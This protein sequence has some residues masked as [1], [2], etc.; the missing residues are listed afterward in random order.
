MGVF[1]VVDDSEKMEDIRLFYALSVFICCVYQS[2]SANPH[3]T[4]Q[5][6]EL[7]GDR[8]DLGSGV[9]V[10]VYRGIP[11][12]Q[13]PTGPLR[14]KPPQ[15]PV[16]WTGV[17]YVT[18]DTS[19]CL[20]GKWP[21]QP[22]ESEDCLYL[23]VYTP[24]SATNSSGFD[25]M[26]V[27][28]WIHGGGFTTGS[29]N[30]YNSTLLAGKGVVVVTVNYRLG[31][32]GFF[33]SNDGVIPGNFGL[34]DQVQALKWVKDNIA[35]FRGDPSQVTIFGESAG[36]MSVSP[37]MISPVAKG[38]THMT[39]IPF[40]FGHPWSIDGTWRRGNTPADDEVSEI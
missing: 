19:Q 33:S 10:D 9:Y 25:N 14:L 3:V 24:S 32:M 37:L 1:Q 38:I 35:K 15:P 2:L 28:V 11:F 29:K 6:G 5:Y 31:P 17:K 16:A 20:Q 13:P 23:D 12:A 7:K 21:A 34:L 8:R 18:T 26:A 36:G 27:M 39:E 40:V 22:G 4:T 30:F